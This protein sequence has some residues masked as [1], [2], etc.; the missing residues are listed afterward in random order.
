MKIGCSPLLF[1]STMQF[2]WKKAAI[3]AAQGGEGEK[4]AR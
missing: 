2:I 4:D 1:L 3:V